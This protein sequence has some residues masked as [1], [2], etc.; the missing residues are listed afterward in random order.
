MKRK[1]SGSVEYTS[2]KIKRIISNI[3]VHLFLTILAFIWV[4]PVLWVVITS[5]RGEKGPGISRIIPKSFTIDNY[6]KLFNETTVL[7]FPKMFM[8]TLI[9][10]LIVC[11]ISTF[12][13]LSVAYSMSR[14]RFK[15]RKP[16][17]N[18]S[19][20]LGLFPGFMSMVAVYY[21]LKAMGLTDGAQLR[22]ALIMVYSGGSGMGFYIAKGFFDTIPKTLDEAA[23][24]DGATKFQVFS[25][26]IMPLSKPIIVHTILTSFMAPWVDFIF[27]RVLTT[28][29]SDYYTVSIGLYNML[30]KEYVVQWFNSFCAGAVLVSIPIAIIF[31]LMQKFYRDG[32]SGAVKG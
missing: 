26:I 16:L 8:N 9:I 28:T 22:V 14:L 18:I 12:F 1:S 20:I 21:I 15:V 27:A 31:L 4:S 3:F 2:A 23:C 19:M 7:N 17:M 30:D 10:A 32:M 6:T 24:I 13:V 5:F 29:K 25:K 11:V